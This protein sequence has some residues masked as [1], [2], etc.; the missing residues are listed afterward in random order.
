[1]E[2]GRDDLVAELVDLSM[3]K[4]GELDSLAPGVLARALRRVVEGDGNP[5]QHWL[6]HQD[7]T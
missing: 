1:M 2:E 3:L 4:L 6:G 5:E 7:S